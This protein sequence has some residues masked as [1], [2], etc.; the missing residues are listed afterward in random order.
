MTADRRIHPR[1][2]GD[3][4]AE[5]FRNGELQPCAALDVSLKGARLH[6]AG[7]YAEGDRILLVLSGE[8]GEVALVATVAS[9]TSTRGE[10]ELR[11]T[12]DGLPPARHRLLRKVL[13]YAVV[14]DEQSG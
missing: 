5:V 6:S 1:V 12:F 13:A 10:S 7:D 9:V 3:L 8:P 11:V 14:P 4:S 2:Q